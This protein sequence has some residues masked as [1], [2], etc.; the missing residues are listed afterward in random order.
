MREIKCKYPISIIRQLRALLSNKE[1]KK[2]RARER[3]RER[4]I[5]NEQI[6]VFALRLPCIINP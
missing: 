3:E 2:E 5:K 4:K 6:N 1:Y